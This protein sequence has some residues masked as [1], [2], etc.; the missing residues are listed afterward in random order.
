ML[1]EIAALI[2]SASSYVF[3]VIW[4]VKW[5]IDSRFSVSNS[6]RI[7]GAK[8]AG[9][10]KIVIVTIGIKVRRSDTR[11][12]L[13][14]GPL[15]I[16]HKSK[17]VTLV[18]HCD[19]HLR[20]RTKVEGLATLGRNE[21]WCMEAAAAELESGQDI[22]R[23]WDSETLAQWC[24]YLKGDSDGFKV[25]GWICSMA[26]L[27]Y[28]AT[29]ADPIWIVG[30]TSRVPEQTSSALSRRT[31]LRKVD[32]A[33]HM[34]CHCWQHSSVFKFKLS[35]IR[36]VRSRK[37]RHRDLLE[38]LKMTGT[39]Q[40]CVHLAYQYVL[41]QREQSYHFHVASY[42]SMVSCI[43][44]LYF[45]SA[46]AVS[47]I[48]TQAIWWLPT[49]P[50]CA[51]TLQANHETLAIRSVWNLHQLLHHLALSHLCHMNQKSAEINWHTT[52]FLVIQMF[53]YISE[54]DLSLRSNPVHAKIGLPEGLKK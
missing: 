26:T 50:N 34:G 12:F 29:T 39:D 25:D 45:V 31:C 8:A 40:S 33:K 36:Q 6:G 9:S 28:S 10:T 13:S 11:S 30:K 1:T 16:V 51:L 49:K 18:P 27:L 24:R 54:T 2:V 41:W 38:Q 20:T 23:E 3:A 7:A 15:N 19:L 5:Y 17:L 21:G 44:K 47:P 32:A 48:S 35:Q 22:E 14:Y 4:A 37:H 42:S 43:H 52:R 46:S 53:L